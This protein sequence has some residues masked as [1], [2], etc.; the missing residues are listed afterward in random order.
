MTVWCRSCI[1]MAAKPRA[2]DKQPAIFRPSCLTAV[3]SVARERL[4][5]AWT[6][7]GIAAVE[8]ETLSTKRAMERRLNMTLIDAPAP[9]ALREALK[10]AAA[11]KRSSVPLDL[12]WAREFERDVLEA[13]RQIPFGE[14]R[15]YSWLARTARRPLAVRAAASVMARNPLWLLV[16]CHR[17]IYADGRLGPYGAG[18]KGQS[19][20]RALLAKEGA[21]PRETRRSSRKRSTQ[22]GRSSA[23]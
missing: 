22:R 11:G 7:A 8:Q 10:I 17:V 15:S 3:V 6:N 4:R 20:K 18:L 2:R 21:H 12:D 19:R 23:Q 9:A 1:A 5:M 16:P 14:T 13:A